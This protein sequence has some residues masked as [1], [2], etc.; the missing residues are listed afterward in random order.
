MK[1]NC[2]NLFDDVG[3]GCI[4]LNDR[5]EIQ[6]MNNLAK[7][8]IEKELLEIHNEI[9]EIIKKNIDKTYSSNVLNYKITFIRDGKLIHVIFKK[10]N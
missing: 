9:K 10:M 3:L 1:C 2:L 7:N 4:I 6:K 8:I 5:G